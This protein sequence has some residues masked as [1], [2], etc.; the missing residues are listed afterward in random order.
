MDIEFVL[1]RIKATGALTQCDLLMPHRNRFYGIFFVA[2][3]SPNCR[4]EVVLWNIAVHANEV[5]LANPAI[6]GLPVGSHHIVG[7]PFTSD[8]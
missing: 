8:R 3:G 7:S 4:K 2:W 1:A 6:D 5:A